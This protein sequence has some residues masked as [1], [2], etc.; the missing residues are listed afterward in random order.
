[1]KRNLLSLAAALA[2]M[3]AMAGGAH[4]QSTPDTGRPSSTSPSTTPNDGSAVPPNTQ[5]PA[6]QIPPAGETN[7]GQRS[8]GSMGSQPNMAY[9]G[10]CDAP[11]SKTGLSLTT[12]YVPN[13][14][15]SSDTMSTPPQC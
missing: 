8:Q 2:V 13:R 3:G 6:G 7:P 12:N 9:S 5:V 1:M 11:G 4:A 15:T 14:N 10:N